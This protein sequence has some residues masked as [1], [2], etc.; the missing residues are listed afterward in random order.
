L[1]ETLKEEIEQGMV[2]VE[3][4]EQRIIV[5]IREKGSFPSGSAQLDP[6]FFEVMEKIS[7][8]LSEAPGSI[9]VAGHTDDIPISTARFRSNWELSAG[10]AVTVAHALLSNPAIDPSRVLVEG[11][12]DT[13]P[14]VPNDS[15]E[16]RALNRR[17]ELVI[18]RGIPDQDGGEV[19]IAIE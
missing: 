9:V 1:Q 4:E 11:H 10:R 19:P 5:R 18:V 12:A 8:K 3:T 14:L 2:E 16:N 15:R 6:G 17:V 7:G 13:K